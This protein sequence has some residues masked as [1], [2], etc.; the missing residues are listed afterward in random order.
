MVFFGGV[1]CA[2]LCLALV[3]VL[4]G[5]INSVLLTMPAVVYT[6][7]LATA[8][9]IIN[10]Y[11]HARATGEPPGAAERGVTAAWMPCLLSAG[12]TSLGLIA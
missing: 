10:Y 7:G 9:H 5:T 2:A 4:G 12:T 3:H 1:Y 6:A 8:M 11:R